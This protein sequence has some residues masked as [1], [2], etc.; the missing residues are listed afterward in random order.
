MSHINLI[1]ATDG[2]KLTHWKQYPKDIEKVYSYFESRAG[3]RWDYTVFFG[4]QYILDRYLYQGV[5]MEDVEQAAKLSAKYL[6]EGQF[7]YHGWAY[8][9]ETLGGKLPL[10]IKAVPEGTVVP[11]HNV[12]MTVQNT[13]PQCAWLTNAME[14]LLTQVWYPSTV[15]TLSHST[16]HDIGEALNDTAMSSAGLP[17]MLHDFGFR[18]VSSYES[19]QI[20]GAAHLVNSMGTDT[21]P[22]LRWIDEWYDGGRDDGDSWGY[23]VPAT[24]H[25]VMTAL[26]EEGEFETIENLLDA[27][28][29][30]ILSIVG[31]S[32]NIYR[33]VD[34]LCAPDLKEKV[35][36]RD[37]KIVV[38]PDSITPN[39]RTPEAEMVWIAEALWRGYGGTANAKAYRVLDPHVGILW[40]DGIDPDGINRILTELELHSFSVECCVFGMG[41]GLLQKINRDTQ[42]FAFKASA[43]KRGGKW[44]EVHKDPLDGSKVSLPGRLALAKVSGKLRT[45]PKG[46]AIPMLAGNEA[47][48][49]QTVFLNGQLLNKTTFGSVRARAAGLAPSLT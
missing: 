43:M 38:R 33:F 17:F 5:T 1:E 37:G 12:M 45:V 19:A 48:V 15:A 13:D 7:N 4:L 49:L 23:S 34:R 32:Y 27:Y 40:G 35:M 30:G 2:Y 41:G 42:R 21:V 22:A 14:T 6:G 28:P 10:K 25:S 24:E 20:G 18:G 31:D 8:I 9:A 16:L 47:N 46:T 36:A 26:G 44:H 29:T 11:V 3:A 39:H